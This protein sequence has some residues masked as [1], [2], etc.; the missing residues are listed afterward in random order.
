MWLEKRILGYS[1]KG[2]QDFYKITIAEDIPS[3][4][5]RS[6]IL[7]HEV[8]H[9]FFKHLDVD[10]IKEIFLVEEIFHQHNISFDRIFYYG[11]PIRFINLTMDLEVNSKVFTLQ[12]LEELNSFL[13]PLSIHMHT[14]DYLK[15][16]I[17]N[18]F[19]DYYNPLILRLNSIDY[20]DNIEDKSFSLNI[21]DD[22]KSH[23]K[24]DFS[25][26]P[27]SLQ[28]EIKK[29]NYDFEDLPAERELTSLEYS[30]IIDQPLEQLKIEKESSE[31]LKNFILC[32]LANKTF[33]RKEDYVKLHNWGIRKNKFIL[34]R[35]SKRKKSRS[36]KDVCFLLDVSNSMKLDCILEA[37][38]SL[39]EIIKSLSLDS[40][41][42]TW[43]THKVQEIKLKNLNS[44]FKVDVGGGTDLAEAIKYIE[45]EGFKDCF[46]YSDFETEPL[47]FLKNIKSSTMNIFGIASICVDCSGI[48]SLKNQSLLEL[49]KHLRDFLIL[50][51]EW[52]SN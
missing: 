25:F 3:Q 45:K 51:K 32:K 33:N 18:T 7:L 26:L 24:P 1:S 41:L 8:G 36:I 52:A 35:S 12:N 21:W 27:S 31:I 15:V 5:I 28:E 44:S 30:Q 6:L 16:E 2:D 34:Y 37:L 47:S 23:I 48:D 42:I 29:E 14:T 13:T 9:I 40:Y 20:I 10:L 11:G 4:N 38:V 50:R 19:R 17:Q 39:K 43:N 22:L 46:I 49:K